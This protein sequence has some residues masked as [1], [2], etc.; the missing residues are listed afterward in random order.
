MK[1]SICPAARVAMALSAV[2][3]IKLLLAW[4]VP[5]TADEAYYAIWGSYLSGGGYDHP[6]MIGFV[7]YPLLKLGHAALIL[8]FPAIISSLILGVVS[9]LYLKK[10]NPKHAAI[11]SILLMI[12]PISL[13]N[14]IITTDTPLFIF[15][16]LSLICVLLAL[17]NNDDWRW[18]ALGGLFLGL[19][20]FSKYFAGLLAL[21]YAVYFLFIAPNRKRLIGLGLLALL[22]LPFAL[23]NAYWNYQHDWANILFNI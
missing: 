4:F 23:Q 22:T 15:S 10:D 17:R 13:F 6:P 8:R 2:L 18:F 9:Y 21:A 11:T 12:A 3:F 14:I 19:A 16:F 1:H 5:I 7:L 20:F